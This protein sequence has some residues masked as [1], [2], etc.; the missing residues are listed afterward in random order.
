MVTDPFFLY[1]G[2]LIFIGGC[3]FL[4]WLL[5]L[6]IEYKIFRWL[7]RDTYLYVT[8]EEHEEDILYV[9]EKPYTLQDLLRKK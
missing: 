3:M 5:W 2:G 6:V 9:N 4:L 1:F 8:K 7:L